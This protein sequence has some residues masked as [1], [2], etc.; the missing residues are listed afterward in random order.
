MAIEM[1]G[2]EYCPLS[3]QDPDQRLQTLLK[4]TECGVVLVHDLTRGRFE[5]NQVTVDIDAVIGR[6]LFT[7]ERSVDR[8]L[9]LM[10]TGESIAYVIFTSGSTGVPKA[11]S[12]NHNVVSVYL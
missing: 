4:E 9:E 5:S 1:A 6:N 11:V 8:S 7:N 2:A 3:P 10:V 12:Y